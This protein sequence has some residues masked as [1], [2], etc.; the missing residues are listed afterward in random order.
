M[1]STLSTYRCRPDGARCRGAGF[2]G[3]ADT[4]NR[5]RIV[6]DGIECVSQ[7]EKLASGIE[8]IWYT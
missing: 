3:T 4:A 7:Q 6:Y 8:A 1:V 2:G 5:K